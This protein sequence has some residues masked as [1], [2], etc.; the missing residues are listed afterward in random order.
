MKNKVSSIKAGYTFG[1]GNYS[2]LLILN[3]Y[4]CTPVNL[5][6]K[7]PFLDCDINNNCVK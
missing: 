7:I 5:C 2:V 4:Q 3:K 1:I 6:A